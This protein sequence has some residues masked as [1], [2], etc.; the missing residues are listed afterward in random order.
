MTAILAAAQADE[1]AARAALLAAL[2]DMLTDT[3]LDGRVP[4][5]GLR[6][7]ARTRAAHE[8]A[9]AALAEAQKAENAAILAR[10]GFRLDL[11][12]RK[13]KGLD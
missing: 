3:I 10:A 7:V 2:D 1:E 11:I 4:D 13:A 6:A 9:E 5:A 8:R 12:A